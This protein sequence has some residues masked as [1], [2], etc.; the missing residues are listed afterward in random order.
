MERIGP[1]KDKKKLIKEAFQLHSQIKSEIQRSRSDSEVAFEKL[2]EICPII[3]WNLLFKSVFREINYESYKN[4][5][6]IAYDSNTLKKVCDIHKLAM[7]TDKGRKTLHSMTVISFLFNMKNILNRYFNE[8]YSPN[9]QMSAEKPTTCIDEVKENFRWTIEK[10]HKYSSISESTENQVLEM[11]KQLKT[12]VTHSL[13]SKSW[14]SED[15]KQKSINLANAYQLSIITSKSL[16]AADRES[17]DFIFNNEISE[18][19]YLM[20]VYYSQ[21]TKFL[22]SIY[23]PLDTDME[24]DASSFMPYISS[25]VENKLIKISAGLLN[26]PYLEEGYSMSEKYG[27]I[28]WLIGRQLMNEVNNNKGAYTHETS[29]FSCISTNANIFEAQLCCL[30]KQDE[31]KGY[32]EKAYTGHED[33]NEKKSF[34]TSF[35]KVLEIFDQLKITLIQLLSSNSWFNENNKGTIDQVKNISLSIISSE[36]LNVE[37]RENKDFIF[38]LAAPQ[39]LFTLAAY[40]YKSTIT[41]ML[42]MIQA[43]KRIQAKTIIPDILFVSGDDQINEPEQSQFICEAT[44]LE[45]FE[46]QLCCLQKQNSFR[47][48]GKKI[49]SG[50]LEAFDAVASSAIDWNLLFESVFREINYESYKN[51]KIIAY[52]SNTLKKVCDIHKLAMETDKGRKTLHSMTVISFLFNMKNILNRYFNEFYS[53]NVQM[54]AEKPT[55]C[56]DEV[57]ENFRWTIEKHHKY[58]SI[59]E[60]T[61]NQVLEMFK[62]LKTTVTHSLSSKS[63]SSEDEKQKSIN[64]ANAYQLS[65]ITSKSLSAADRESRDFI[66]N[67]EISEDD[68]LMN[69]YYSQKTKLLKSIY[70]PLDTDME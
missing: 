22:K 31:F 32:N 69:A 40:A 68:Y 61:E 52:D 54:S 35:A 6:I 56:I 48:F 66:F 17:R 14:S 53:P 51:M 2:T 64:L 13:S 47:M 16:S 39:M 24:P 12:T 34:Y 67:N 5:K 29:Q 7:E 59:S 23:K 15:E 37:E 46:S 70:K 1:L 45:S 20:N 41:I 8:F 62:Q 10:H 57:K 58:S 25:S 28:G 30:Q 43:I 42:C 49:S 18:D 50:S 44:D 19:D 11:F 38:N 26:P 9:V 4:M 33:F 60:S 3:D 55:T 65:I 63:W 27:T 21:K 36:S